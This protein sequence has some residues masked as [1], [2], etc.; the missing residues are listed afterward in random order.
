MKRHAQ[1]DQRA[2]LE[3]LSI[4]LA[5]RLELGATLAVRAPSRH[6]R[7]YRKRI[8]RLAALACE[9]A[10]LAGAMQALLDGDP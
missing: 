2:I 1:P 3:A 7:A 9:A 10:N 4:A 5:A 8:Q 6:H